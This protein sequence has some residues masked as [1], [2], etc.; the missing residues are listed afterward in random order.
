MLQEGD[1]VVGEIEIYDNTGNL[2]ARDKLITKLGIGLFNKQIEKDLINKDEQKE[3]IL[4]YN[5]ENNPFGKRKPELIRL[6]KISEFRKRGINPIPGLIVNI[7]GFPAVILSVSG[8]R[9]LVD[10]N[11]PLAGKKI[12]IVVKDIKKLDKKEWIKEFANY[13]GL[14]Q[15]VEEKEGKIVITNELLKATLEKLGISL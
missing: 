9:V 2:L 8:G 6:V 12:K 15:F 5:E 1:L 13:L 7:N 10:F 11:N 3:I 4:E 14:S